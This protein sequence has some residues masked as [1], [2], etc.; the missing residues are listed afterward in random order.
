MSENL[1]NDNLK[2]RCQL[3]TFRVTSGEFETIALKAKKSGVSK[4]ELCRRSLLGDSLAYE[5]QKTPYAA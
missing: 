5:K 2:G 3:I 1:M 4:S